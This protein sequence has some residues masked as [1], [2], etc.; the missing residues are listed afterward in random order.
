M[1][2]PRETPAER[3]RRIAVGRQLVQ[4]D[5]HFTVH[6]S[7]VEAAETWRKRHRSHPRGCA[8]DISE[9][10]FTPTGIGTVVEVKCK[11]CQMKNVTDYSQW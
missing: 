11:C 2:A 6:S 3:R 10:R 7:E 9:W 5:A 1:T 8:R 4:G